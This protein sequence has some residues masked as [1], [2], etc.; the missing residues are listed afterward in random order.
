MYSACTYLE[1]VEGWRDTEDEGISGSGGRNE[2]KGGEGR[3]NI[4][5]V[6]CDSD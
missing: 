3:I 4:I 1:S 5:Y 6:S 2:G